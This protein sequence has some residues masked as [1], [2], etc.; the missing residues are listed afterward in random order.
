MRTILLFKAFKTSQSQLKIR[1]DCASLNFGSQILTQFFS[2]DLINFQFLFRFRS[3]CFM[4]FLK[5]WITIYPWSFFL[6]RCKEGFK[7]RATRYLPYLTYWERTIWSSKVLLNLIEH[8]NPTFWLFLSIFGYFYCS[9]SNLQ[10]RPGSCL[11][12]VPGVLPQKGTT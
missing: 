4:T 2:T 12:F 7:N 3:D 11:T 1:T 8:K 9:G 5:Y 10:C 6:L